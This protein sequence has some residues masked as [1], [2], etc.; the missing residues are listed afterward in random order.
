MGATAATL[1]QSRTRKGH[2]WDTAGTQPC[3]RNFRGPF[4]T[5]QRHLT[6]PY[7]S[8]LPPKVVF[9]DQ[10]AAPRPSPTNLPEV[11][12]KDA[13]AP[14]RHAHTNKHVSV[15]PEG[16]EVFGLEFEEEPLGVTAEQGHGYIRVEFVDAIGPDEEPERYKVVRKLGWGM[17]SSVWL[18]FD[19]KEEKY[20]AIKALK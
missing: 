12:F 10:D 14:P 15:D 1:V 16:N 6:R 7:S 5:T 17:N 11:V 2:T 9:V 3:V 19:V 18:A 8:I 20:V 13:D 4:S